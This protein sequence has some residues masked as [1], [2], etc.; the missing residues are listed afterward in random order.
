MTQPFTDSVSSFV[1]LIGRRWRWKQRFDVSDPGRSGRQQRLSIKVSFGLFPLRVAL[2]LGGGG[3]L[4][5]V[6]AA[7]FVATKRTPFT[8]LTLTAPFYSLR[9]VVV[10]SDTKSL[11]CVIMACQ[12]DR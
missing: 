9:Y 4:V 8:R 12:R 7:T 11:I 6:V 3:R 5:G 2:T 10:W 1:R